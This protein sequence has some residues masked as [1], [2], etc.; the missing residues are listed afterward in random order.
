[1]YDRQ[2]VGSSSVLRYNI[3]SLDLKLSTIR[4]TMKSCEQ[5]HMPDCSSLLYAFGANYNLPDLLKNSDA[6][7][8]CRTSKCG[9]VMAH[10]I[11]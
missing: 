8:R 9:L 4:I 1:M 2:Y 3:K 5:E 11:C 10:C 6:N 7:F